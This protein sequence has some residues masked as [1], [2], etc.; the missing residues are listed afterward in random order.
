MPDA[1]ATEGS[2]EQRLGAYREIRDQL[3]KRVRERFST[4]SAG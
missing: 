3:A 4:A 2:R 1:T